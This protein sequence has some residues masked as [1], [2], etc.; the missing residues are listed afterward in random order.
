[1]LH[2]KPRR[3]ENDYV[4]SHCVYHHCLFCKLKT[5]AS[6]Q[7]QTLLVPSDSLIEKREGGRG[8]VK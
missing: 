3:H 4:T 1:M 7:D 8:L 2:P 5:Y 6:L